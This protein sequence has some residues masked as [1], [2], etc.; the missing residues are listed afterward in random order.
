MLW[1]QFLNFCTRIA[2]YYGKIALFESHCDMKKL[3]FGGNRPHESIDL[4]SLNTQN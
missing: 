2:Q 3:G 1:V 4:T